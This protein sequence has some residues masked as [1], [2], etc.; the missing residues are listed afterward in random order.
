LLPKKHRSKT[1]VGATFMVAR[2]WG[3]LSVHLA[4]IKG[5]GPRSHPRRATMKALTPT[6]SKRGLPKE[7]KRRKI[8]SYDLEKT[9]RSSF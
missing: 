2:W 5:T 4:H 9:E 7:Q 8:L 1:S 6:K 3:M